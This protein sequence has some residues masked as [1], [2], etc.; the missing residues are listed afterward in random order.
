MQENIAEIVRK[1]WRPEGKVAEMAD[2]SAQAR[3]LDGALKV[4]E[5]WMDSAFSAQ[6]TELTAR[7]E[8][9]RDQLEEELRACADRDAR[10][11]LEMRTQAARS[12]GEFSK[13]PNE[14]VCLC[15]PSHHTSSSPSGNSLPP[16]CPKGRSI[17]R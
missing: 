17:I 13:L 10:R 1:E 8:Y 16:C 12:S 11:L 9:M 14:G 3:R 5:Q 7:A 4:A 15:P 2:L 6:S